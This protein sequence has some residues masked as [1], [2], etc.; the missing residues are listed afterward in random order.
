MSGAVNVEILSNSCQLCA[1]DDVFVLLVRSVGFSMCAIFLP[2]GICHC[3]V[4]AFSRWSLS[5]LV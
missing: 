2:C 3:A 4:L 1:L 5:S